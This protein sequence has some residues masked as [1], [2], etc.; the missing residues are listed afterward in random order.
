MGKVTVAVRIE[1]VVDAFNAS[2]G[3]LAPEQVRSVEVEDAVVDSGA[4]Q[5]S[6]PKT[7]L[8]SLG[9][10]F[11]R[12]R[13]AVTAAGLVNVRVFGT[14]RL[15]VQGRDCPVDIT[16]LPDG[17]PVLIGSS[18]LEGMDFVIDLP[19][20]RVIGNPTHGGEQIIYLC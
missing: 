9:L 3:A 19:S 16:E 7:M 4:T 12:N 5:L 18:S 1:N 2:Q 10:T 6:M 17:C 14:A 20:R 8:A 11:L 13:K 15:T